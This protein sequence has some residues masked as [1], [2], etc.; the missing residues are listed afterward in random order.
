M[1]IFSSLRWKIR[2]DNS[3]NASTCHSAPSFLTRCFSLSLA[4][5]IF[6]SPNPATPGIRFSSAIF[7][8]GVLAF[9]LLACESETLYPPSAQDPTHADPAHPPGRWEILPISVSEFPAENGWKYVRVQIAFENKTPIFSRPAI[10]VNG[11]LLFSNHYTVPLAYPLEAFETTGYNTRTVTILDFANAITVNGYS[12]SL[13]PGFRFGGAYRNDAVVFYYFQAK[14]AI[15]AT[16]VK[17]HIPPY[18]GDVADEDIL[19]TPT[20]SIANPMVKYDRPVQTTNTAPLEIA[21]KASLVVTDITLK[22]KESSAYGTLMHD[23]VEVKI[24]LCNTIPGKD[25]T[26]TLYAT[27]IGSKGV[28]GTPFYDEV[29]GCKKPPF[30]LG[31][32]QEITTTICSIL[33]PDS[34]GIKVIMTG[35]V[36]EV[37][38]TPF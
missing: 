22:K 36:N 23:R 5:K 27:A 35:D 4:P 1:S 29:L 25:T 30:V 15:G 26:V 3:I 14:T 31:P 9:L 12:T 17:L 33:P 21:G 13:P 34:S 20:L 38:I 16:P 2:R 11:S 19:L 32:R 8:L 37:Y 24:K 6:R 10:P 28:L 18:G 7:C